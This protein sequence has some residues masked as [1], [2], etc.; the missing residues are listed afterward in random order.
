[1]IDR[2]L[3]PVALL[4]ANGGE[5]IDGRTRMQKLVFLIQEEFE[6]ADQQL[7]GTYTY[8]PYDYGPFARGLYDDLDRLK[9]EGVIEEKKTEMA[10]GTIKYEYELS[11]QADNYLS[12]LPKKKLQ[13]TLELAE[14]IKSKFNNTRLPELL[15][16]VY[17][18]YP[19][20]AANS[21]L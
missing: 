4:Q 15:D 7:P 21:V 14:Q 9:K 2:E 19:E 16:Y 18:E 6:D 1:M 5:E 17:S 11:D 20:Y 10:D 8:V 12:Q 3:L 13:R